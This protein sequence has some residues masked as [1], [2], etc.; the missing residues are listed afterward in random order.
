MMRTMLGRPQRTMAALAVLTLVAASA[1]SASSSSTTSRQDQVEARGATVM[2]FDQRRTTHVFHST[3][4]G[5]VQRVVAKDASDTRQIRLVRQHLR[6]EAVRFRVGD[7]TDPMAIHGMKM[8]G[9][10]P[11]RRGAARV[12]VTY[13]PIPRGARITYT[14]AEP[15]LVTALHAWF[16]AQLMDHGSNAHS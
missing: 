6:K 2:P 16:D 4:T 10:E 15:E 13:A 7:F 11:L 5:G 1:C 9:L 3:A 8:P 14:T 12:D